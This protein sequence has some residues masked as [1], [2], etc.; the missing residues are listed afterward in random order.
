[1]VELPLKAS[2]LLNV[3][4]LGHILMSFIETLY[5]LVCSQLLTLQILYIF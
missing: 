4:F 1:M 2:I 3:A 5:S